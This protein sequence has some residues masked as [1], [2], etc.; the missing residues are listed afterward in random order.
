MSG[1]T[2]SQMGGDHYSSLDVQPLDVAYAWGLSGALYSSVKYIARHGRKGPPV[3]DLQK[4]CHFI[5]LEMEKVHGCK[6]MADRVAK[7]LNGED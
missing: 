3:P 2:R 4:A 5:A 6:G 1:I 7:A